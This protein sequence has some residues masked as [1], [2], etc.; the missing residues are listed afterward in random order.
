[1]RRERV[2]QRERH[3]PH[4]LVPRIKAKGGAIQLQ[5]PEQ[6]LNRTHWHAYKRN[7]YL[8]QKVHPQHAVRRLMVHFLSLRLYH[9]RDAP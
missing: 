3:L 9:V 6:G 4:A 7:K 2:K 1:M 8:K 5:G